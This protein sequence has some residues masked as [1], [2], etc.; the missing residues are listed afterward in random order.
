METLRAII[1]EDEPKG[2]KNLLSILGTHCPN[3][4]V[5]GT[6]GTLAN[7]RMGLKSLEPDLIFLDVHLPDG[8]GF[9]LLEDHTETEASIIFITAYDDFALK[10][11][12]LGAIH[13]LLKPVVTEELIG[14]VERAQSLQQ[15]ETKTQMGFMHQAYQQ[16]ISKIALPTAD[17]IQ[18]VEFDQIKVCE[19]SGPYTV[20]H[21][22]SGEQPVV[23][24][25]LMKF[26]DSLGP[27]HFLRIHDRYL[28]NLK[29]VKKYIK[30]RG[31]QVVM[32]DDTLLGVSSR[33]KE[34]FLKAME[35]L[36]A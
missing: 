34:H 8:L 32:Q 2:L 6:Y 13:Y 26:E 19:A 5:V 17:G 10:A 16:G 22:E 23:S 9:Q 25:N 31:G 36:L 18:Y 28:I 15:N 1:V 14:A 3:V 35:N 12:E 7:A 21:L 33:R 30:G 4:E 11:F 24:K 29:K 20:L 27:Y